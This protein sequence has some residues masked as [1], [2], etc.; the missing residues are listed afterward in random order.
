MK[1]LTDFGSRDRPSFPSVP[2]RSSKAVQI[3][4]NLVLIVAERF[5]NLAG[6]HVGLGSHAEALPGAPCCA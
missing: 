6:S 2:I 3:A 1:P 4:G 5:S